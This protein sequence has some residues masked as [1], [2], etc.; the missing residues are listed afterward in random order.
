VWKIQVI[1][2]E[3]KRSF[4]HTDV[5]GIPFSKMGMRDTVDWLLPSIYASPSTV[6]VVTANPEVVMAAREDEQLKEIL[7]EAELITADGI[8]V[9]WASRQ[10]ADP[11]AER[12]AGYDLLHELCQT[13]SQKPF[14]VYIFGASEEV[15]RKATEN[16]LN[17]Y[18]NIKLAGRRNGYYDEADESNIVREIN[19]A[20]PDLLL[21]ALGV[22]KQE[23]FIYRYKRELK[24]NVAIGVGGSLDVLAG[25]VKRAPLIWQKLR[26]EWLYRLL[27]QPSRWRRQLVLPRFAI[28]VLQ[29][30]QKRKIIK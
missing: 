1:D 13:S 17:A 20:E 9:V 4:D 2:V 30:K 14:S 7:A 21:V 27:C 24:A 16:L 15:N 5:L 26:L 19:T 25:A 22:P 8:G 6:H 3:N 29:E 10:F 12:V 23:R 18:P 28:K 11:I